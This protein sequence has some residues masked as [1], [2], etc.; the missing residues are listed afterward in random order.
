MMN[1]SIN[2]EILWGEAWEFRWIQV[3]DSDKAAHNLLKRK[4]NVIIL[5]YVYLLSIF[6][7]D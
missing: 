6:H 1:F 4:N 5:H 3:N 2:Y 7:G